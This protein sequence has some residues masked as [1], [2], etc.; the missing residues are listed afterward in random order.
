MV[1]SQCGGRAKNACWWMLVVVKMAMVNL[2]RKNLNHS[3][4]SGNG[5]YVCLALS[6]RDDWGCCCWLKRKLPWL[7]CWNSD[8]FFCLFERVERD[9]NTVKIKRPR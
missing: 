9:S 3:S 1:M 7:N 4:G 8:P 5:G 2:A 6:N